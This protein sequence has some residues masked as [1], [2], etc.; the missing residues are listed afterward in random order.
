MQNRKKALLAAAVGVLAVAAAGGVASYSLYK[1]SPQE[2]RPLSANRPL[3]KAKETPVLVDDR[4]AKAKTASV[5]TAPITDFNPATVYSG[6][7]GEVTSLQAGRDINKAAFEMMEY[8]LKLKELEGKLKPESLVLPNISASPA[9]SNVPM[10]AAPAGQPSLLSQPQDRIVVLSVKGS[11]NRLTATLR[12]RSGTYTVHVG[13]SIPGF[14]SVSS[15]TRD[16]VVLNGAAV[17]WL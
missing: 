14:G 3:A 12:S 6:T 10:Q 11:D 16:R 2:V 15:I 13:E 9:V 1:P 5:E 8:Q 17:P 4:D 7:L